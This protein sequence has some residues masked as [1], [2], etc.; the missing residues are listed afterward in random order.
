GG[1]YVPVRVRAPGGSLVNARRPAAV[2]AGNTETSSRIVDCLFS[3][4]GQAVDVQAQGQGTMNNVTFG[5]SRFTYYETIAGGQG[6]CS[7]SSGP[8]SVPGER[9]DSEN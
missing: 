1:V 7:D 4:F 6:A 8:N 2:V 5:N 3:A 9:S